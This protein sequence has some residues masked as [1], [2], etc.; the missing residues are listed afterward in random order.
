MPSFY[1]YIMSNHAHTLYVGMTGDL[2]RRARQHKE[3]E[4]PEAF[5]ARY[6]YDRLVY[7]EVLPSYVAAI[8]REKQ[9]KGW[10]RAKKVALVQEHNPHW[11]DLSTSYTEGLR[12]D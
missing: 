9:L 10:S 11:L 1:A 6:T 12:L 7:F 2:I 4:F 3:R 8:K 5:T